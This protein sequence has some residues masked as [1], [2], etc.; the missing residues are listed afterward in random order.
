MKRKVVSL[1][2]PEKYFNKLEKFTEEE[3]KSRSQL[4]REL[5][6]RYEADEVWEEIF[7]WG[8]ETRRKFNIKNEKDVLRIIND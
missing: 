2:L 7:K 1:S 4:I 5:L 6:D 8:A 3:S